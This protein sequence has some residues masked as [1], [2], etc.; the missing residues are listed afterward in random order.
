M[1]IIMWRTLCKTLYYGLAK[2]F[3]RLAKVTVHVQISRRSDLFQRGRFLLNVPSLGRTAFIHVKVYVQKK[4]CK[5]RTLAYGTTACYRIGC[6]IVLLLFTASTF[7]IVSHAQEQM[8]S[9]VSPTCHYRRFKSFRSGRHFFTFRV[10][11]VF[12]I[13]RRVIFQYF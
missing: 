7:L 9:L 5:T 1:V 2:N 4:V 3:T 11:R 8:S 13:T 12:R 10:H 6:I